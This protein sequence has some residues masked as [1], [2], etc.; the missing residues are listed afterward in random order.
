MFSTGSYGELESML[1]TWA[2]NL[3]FGGAQTVVTSVTTKSKA[4]ESKKKGRKLKVKA[5][6]KFSAS[7]KGKLRKGTAKLK[8]KYT[9]R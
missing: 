8:G 1:D 4:T 3:G 2:A 7:L 9:P 6:V 5:K